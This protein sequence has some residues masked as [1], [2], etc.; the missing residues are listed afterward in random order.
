MTPTPA[1][2]TQLEDSE[3]D[4]LFTRDYAVLQDSQDPLQHL[5]REF[6]IPTRASLKSKT[7]GQ[8]GKSTIWVSS[9]GSDELCTYLCGNSLGLQ[10]KK[11]S[12]R[13]QQYLSTWATQGVF[14]HF[15]PLSDSPLAT[16]LDVD[17]QAATMIAPVVGAQRSEVAVM[18]TLTANLHLLMSAFYR[19]DPKARH[20]IILESKAFPSDHYAVESQICNH[21]LDP[22][23]SM[24][25]IEPPSSSS[26]LLSTEYILDVISEHAATTAL[27]LLPGIQFYSGQYFD[28]PTITAHARSLGIFV[29]WDLAH[30]VGNVPL[31]LHDWDVD[32]AAWCS[33]KYLNAGPGTIGGLF[34][35]ERHS[36][37]AATK[38]DG[39]S[40]SSDYANRLS[41]WWGSDKAARFHMTNQFQPSP[42]A[43]SFQLSNPSVLDTTALCASLDLFA[44][45]S[46]DA[47]RAKSLHLT[48]YLETLLLRLQTSISTRGNS[49]NNDD[50]VPPAAFTIITPADPAQ[51]GAQLS[52]QLTPPGL[53]LDAVMRELERRAVV[54]DE[55]RPDVIRVAP[56]PLYNSFVDVWVFVEALAAAL[57][58]VEDERRTTRPPPPAPGEGQ[59]KESGLL[60]T[61]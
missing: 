33:Y 10:P 53:L 16:W 5:R 41:G 38:A 27:L 61:T 25:T 52:L 12:E 2:P 21:N 34:V 58:A 1:A 8:S 7:L 44:L 30:A 36:T 29:I 3:Q 32:A 18:Q 17:D 39:P 26:P 14:G 22:S 48:A 46:M 50:D 59:E 51:R 43:R 56:A 55:R 23:T 28:M 19:P 31:H 57:A 24:V 49:S 54:V 47:L 35:H 11:T 4:H 20:K 15:K 6:F 9:E 45:T 42:G 60:F 40:S 37:S 13:I